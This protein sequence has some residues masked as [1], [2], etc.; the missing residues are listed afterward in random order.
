[1]RMEHPMSNQEHPEALE[2]VKSKR[3]TVFK[4]HK[5]VL[6]LTKAIPVA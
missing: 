3:V 2:P 6:K 4:G 1:M 5:I